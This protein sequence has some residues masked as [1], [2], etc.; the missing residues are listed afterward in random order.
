ML[1]PDIRV[2]HQDRRTLHELLI[3]G[4]SVSRL[5]LLDLPMRVG[6]SIVRMG[7]IA[8][9][10][11]ERSDPILAAS[12]A[13]VGAWKRSWAETSAPNLSRRRD[14]TRTASSECPPNSKKSSWIPMSRIPGS[15][16]Q[17][18]ATAR[19]TSSRGRS[20]A[21]ARAGRS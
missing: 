5:L 18:S 12:A 20:Y 2:T 4:R 13:T 10:G 15:S 3:D 1:D 6:R 19:S 17:I 14:A 21:V 16:D 9:V 7:G 11:T 8:G